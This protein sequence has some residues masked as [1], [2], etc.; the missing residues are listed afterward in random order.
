[1]YD[2]INVKGLW[3]TEGAYSLTCQP[4]H[5]MTLNR[6]FAT[7]K[8]RHKENLPMDSSSLEPQS[9]YIE[10]NSRKLTGIL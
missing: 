2:K 1:M 10:S 8:R 5:F 6:D 9:S 3:L 4:N 7:D